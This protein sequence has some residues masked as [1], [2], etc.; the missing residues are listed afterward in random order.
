MLTIRKSAERGHAD[1][2]WLDTYHSFSFADYHDPDHMGF[3]DLRVINEDVVQPAL[4]FGTHGHRDMEILTWVLEGQL[5]HKDSMESGGIIHPGELQYMSAGRGVMHS[6]FNAS[7]SELV[8]LL[9]IWILPDEQSAKP[10]YG[11]KSFAEAL[12][13]GGLVLLASKAGRDG[14][15]AIRQNVDLF[16]ARLDGAK[17]LE[18]HSRPD[19]MPGSRW[20]ADRRA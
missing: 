13:R 3:R 19:G 11:Q 5:E 20:R 12:E 17:T 10:R 18:H 9:Q 2:G 15:I 4:G 7:K 16:V 1:H 6:E 8:K 14:S